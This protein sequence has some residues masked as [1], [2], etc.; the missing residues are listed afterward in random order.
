MAGARALAREGR[1]PGARV[2]IGEPTNLVP[3][4]RHKG[5]FMEQVRLTGRSG[6][7]SDPAAGLNAIEG[8]LE[9][10]RALDAYR[11]EMA[12]CRDEAFPVPEPTLNLGRIHGGD[13]PNRICGACELSVDVRIP[14][15]G[16]VSGFREALRRRVRAAIDGRGYGLEFDA[17]FEGIDPLVPGEERALA[18]ACAEVSGHACGAVSFGTEGPFFRALG[19]EVVVFGPGEIRL[20]HQ[21]DESVALADVERAV[22]MTGRLIHRFCGAG[23]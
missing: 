2:I 12:G 15:G 5:I 21:P 11:R 22:E 4:D 23:P 20:A 18:Q 14:P 6:H 16:R 7:A 1:R 19:M 8:M 3:V 10:V 17:L 13:N 9:V